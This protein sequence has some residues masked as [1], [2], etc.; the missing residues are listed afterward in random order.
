MDTGRGG[1]GALKLGGR[2]GQIW[3]EIKRLT[4][5]WIG[6]PE[7]LQRKGSV[8]ESK[9]KKPAVFFVFFWSAVKYCYG[10]VNLAKL[11]RCQCNQRPRWLN[12]S[13]SS[14]LLVY[15]C[16]CAE[17]KNI[18]MVIYTVEFPNNEPKSRLM[19]WDTHGA[20]GLEFLHSLQTLHSPL[21][22]AK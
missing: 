6:I 20:G 12:A 22:E 17:E 18:S 16:V 14:D 11:W 1:A 5:V 3:H 19:L 9:L 7:E 4:D 21:V 10:A 2:L 13:T 15:G 8:C